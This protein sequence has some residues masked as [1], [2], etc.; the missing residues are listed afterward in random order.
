MSHRRKKLLLLVAILVVSLA[1]LLLVVKYVGQQIKDDPD[2]APPIVQIRNQAKK[3]I[4]QRRNAIVADSYVGYTLLPNVVQLVQTDDFDFRRITDAR[5]F[6]NSGNWPDSADIVFLGDSLIMAEG[7]GLDNGLVGL[8]DRSF[9]NKRIVNLGNPGAGLERQFRIYEKYG[10]DLNPRLVV[11]VF[12]VSS[13][14]LNDTHFF[15]WLD[16]PEG[17]TYNEFRLSYSRRNNPRSD[18]SFLQRLQGH[19]L[20]HWAVS[21]V[22]P[23]LW[24]ELAVEHRA[25]MPDGAELLFNRETVMFAKTAFDG[26]EREFT[27][28]RTSLNRL[29]ASVDASDADLL[30]VLLPSKEELFAGDLAQRGDSAVAVAT[31]ELE[32][33]EI[34]YLDLYPVLRDAASSR[35]PYFRRD[36]HLNDFGNRVVAEAIAQWLEANGSG[37]GP[38]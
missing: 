36:P 38:E 37:A 21:V 33:R 20:Y 35:T 22:E 1:A 6:P 15:D 8:V 4:G 5:G 14:L 26:S 23:R 16:A 30:V 29:V 25:T 18:K 19:V 11:A 31:I 24:G 27:N 10:K 7:V 9:A 13:D 32:S 2:R 3:L 34:H 12:F 17:L 28:F